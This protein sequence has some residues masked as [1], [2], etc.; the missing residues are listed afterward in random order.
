MAVNILCQLPGCQ[1]TQLEMETALGDYLQG[2]CKVRELPDYFHD[3]CKV[4]KDKETM[5]VFCWGALGYMLGF[6]KVK[7]P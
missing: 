5:E 4:K 7:K 2:F 3:S 6:C 1:T